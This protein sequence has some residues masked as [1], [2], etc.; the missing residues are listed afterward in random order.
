MAAQKSNFLL[1]SCYF[2]VSTQTITLRNFTPLSTH[3]EMDGSVRFISDDDDEDDNPAPVQSPRTTRSSINA[4]TNNLTPGPVPPRPS[5]STDRSPVVNSSKKRKRAIISPSP[6][7][8]ADLPTAVAILPEEEDD[9]A[10]CPIC[11]DLWDMSGEHRLTSL[12][13]GH[14]FGASCIRRWLNE[15]PTGAKSCPTCKTKATARDFRYL[16]AKKLCAVDNTELETLKSRYDDK[17][18]E[19]VKMTSEKN[20]VD[21]ELQHHRKRL[22][23][24]QVDYDYLRKRLLDSSST[25]EATGPQKQMDVDLARL[26]RVKNVRLFLEKNI[27]ISKEMAGCRYM[28]NSR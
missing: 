23:Q 1:L 19:F 5:L 15:C 20:M 22:V 13:C 26:T 25:S 27:E 4:A 3:A 8:S 11:L 12:K 16:F 24:L 7:K 2:D 18:S 14:L 28:T 17:C 6:K 9:G 10:T 21:Y